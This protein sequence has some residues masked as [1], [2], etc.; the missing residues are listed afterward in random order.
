MATLQPSDRGPL[1]ISAGIVVAGLFVALA[2]FLSRSVASAPQV[3]AS[4]YDPRAT[5][6][7]APPTPLVDAT[8]TDTATIAGLR[9]VANA[10]TAVGIPAGDFAQA[11]ILTLGKKA[12][13]FTYLPSTRPSSRPN[14][15][16]ISSESGSW[17]A[18]SQSES[19]T[20]F[21]IKLTLD[22]SRGEAYPT[23]G[24]GTPC[25]GTA[26]QTANQSAFPGF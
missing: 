7:I 23:Y 12:A 26:A 11:D 4:P 21:W 3:A 22:A 15:M 20:C 9:E 10:A 17:A 14:E 16:S 13:Q 5:V 19:G 24:A 2:L 1:I 18:A 6:E 8:T 25:T